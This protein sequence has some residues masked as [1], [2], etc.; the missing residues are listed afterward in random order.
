MEP[1]LF[2]AETA[3]LPESPETGS[4]DVSLSSQPRRAPRGVSDRRTAF[5][6][7]VSRTSAGSGVSSK[8]WGD[9]SLQN[10]FQTPGLWGLMRPR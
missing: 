5:R 4:G 7:A 8:A 3:I 1:M 9:A 10:P 2:E 6:A